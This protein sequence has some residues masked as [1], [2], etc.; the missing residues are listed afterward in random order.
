ML[1]IFNFLPCSPDILTQ[2]I[3]SL[4]QSKSE[5]GLK[6]NLRC[7]AALKKVKAAKTPKTDVDKKHEDGNGQH[8]AGEKVHDSA[9]TAETPAG[10]AQ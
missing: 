2:V 9:K 7:V 10:H 1:L 5:D 6:L 3:S 4:M 8:V